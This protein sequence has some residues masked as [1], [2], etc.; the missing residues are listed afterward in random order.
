ME[1]PFLLRG[2]KGA[3]GFYVGFV[4]RSGG[5]VLGVEITDEV[6]VRFEAKGI[7]DAFEG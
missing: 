3:A 2:D 4:C 7:G 5:V 1:E 6:V